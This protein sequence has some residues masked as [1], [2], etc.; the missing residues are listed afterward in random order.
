M[1]AAPL[2]GSPMG[3]LKWKRAAA[4]EAKK[5][6]AGRRDCCFYGKQRLQ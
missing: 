4:R 5:S 1:P 6:N 2:Q 3:C